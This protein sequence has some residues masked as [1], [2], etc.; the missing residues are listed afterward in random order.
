MRL[1]GPGAAALDPRFLRLLAAD[2]DPERRARFVLAPV[3]PADRPAVV[4]EH[5]E[6]LAQ[7]VVHAPRHVR[8]AILVDERKH[9]RLEGREFALEL[10]DDALVLLPLPFLSLYGL[11]P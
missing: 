10:A 2:R 11:F 9:G 7:V 3:A 5:V 1:Q 8:H 4:V 6:P